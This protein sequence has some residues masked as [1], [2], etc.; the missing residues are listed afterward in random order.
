MKRAKVSELKAHLSSYLAE[1]RS[2]ETVIVCDRAT[3]FA[4]LVPLEEDPGELKIR[5]A[6]KPIRELNVRS[7]RLRKKVDLDRLLGE[8]RGE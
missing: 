1:V 2:G 3:P 4:R 7:V 6:G 5:E 8:M